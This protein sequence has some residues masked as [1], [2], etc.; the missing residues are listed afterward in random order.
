MLALVLVLTSLTSGFCMQPAEAQSAEARRLL[1]EAMK[2]DDLGKYEEAIATYKKVIELA[3]N[4][5][6]PYYDMGISYDNKKDYQTSRK[7]YEKAVELAPNYGT[8]WERLG[9]VCHDLKDLDA[10]E[11]AHK[12]AM[13]FLPKSRT[14]Y[15]NLSLVY[16]DRKDY[17]RA[18]ELLLRAKNL[19]EGTSMERIDNNLRVLKDYLDK[20]NTA[21]TKDIK[22]GESKTEKSKSV[23]H[24]TPEDTDA[25]ELMM[26]GSPDAGK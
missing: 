16:C 8:A 26:K 1:D 22:Q 18:Y 25:W 20:Q 15:W 7:L 23:D 13:V 19:P 17:K 6:A 5:E 2:L 10:A 11:R 4:W 9:T 21:K 24:K 3:P 12:K 14:P